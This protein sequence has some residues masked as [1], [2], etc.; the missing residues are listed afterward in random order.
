MQVLLF[1]FTWDYLFRFSPKPV[2]QAFTYC[3]LSV[4]TW[5]ELRSKCCVHG[6]DDLSFGD[7]HQ[8][9]FLKR[10]LSFLGARTFGV[11]RPQ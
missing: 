9:L 4:L 7:Q 6:L 3:L 2:Q 8:D 11:S 1:S 10:G 5:F